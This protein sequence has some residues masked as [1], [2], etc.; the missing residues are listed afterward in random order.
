MNGKKK[1][2]PPQRRGETVRI[3]HEVASRIRDGHPWI[4]EDALRGRKL[5]FDV[6][7]VIDIVDPDGKFVARALFDST[8]SPILRVV[9]RLPGEGMSEREL[10]WRIHRSEERRRQMM[11]FSP[12]ACYRVMSGDSEGI[13][14]VTIDRYGS[15]LVVCFYSEVTHA[16][17]QALFNALSQELAP[18]GIY[19]QRRFL[20]AVPG[21]P[22]PG[23]ELVWGEPAPT[24][25]VVTE[26]KVRYVV[27]V[28]G[29]A[30]TGI[31][32]DMRLGRRAVARLA[33]GRRVLNCFSYSGAFSV[34]AALHGASEVVSVDAA[35]KA[36]GW[37]RRNFAENGLDRENRAF[38]FISGDT[39]AVLAQMAERR[40]VFD[41]I[42][43]D[44]PTFSSSK[45]RPFT[46]LKDY[47]D[48]V[49]AALSVTAQGGLI[50][51]A[52]NAAKM[53]AADLDRAL[54]RGANIASRNLI[55]QQQIG[56]PPDFPTSPSFPEG[57]Y[58]KIFVAS[59]D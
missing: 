7:A 59:A 14:A 23:A 13:P 25:F 18:Q 48:L 55:V 1:S 8:Q 57:S 24:D 58:L 4:F 41:L 3:P 12:T 56:Q 9:S 45:G 10:R 33:G 31:Y 50:L 29:P 51:A 39:F 30:G 5:S 49:A 22:R 34:V 6:G 11:D 42:I 40:R 38:E 16:F 17:E 47:A 2:T 19:L 43:L 52:S 15:Y 32:P 37:A 27:D 54:G 21:R 44:P 36:H 28:T 20:P 46:A 53:P 26:G 35:T